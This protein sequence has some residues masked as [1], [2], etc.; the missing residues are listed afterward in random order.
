MLAFF[1]KQQQ[2]ATYRPMMAAKVD[3]AEQHNAWNQSLGSLHAPS[4]QCNSI[5]KRRR[6]RCEGRLCRATSCVGRYFYVHGKVSRGATTGSRP[7]KDWY[8]LVMMFFVR[9]LHLFGRTA[10]KTSTYPRSET[11]GLSVDV[12]GPRRTGPSAPGDADHNFCSEA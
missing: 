5:C 7:H 9:E 8:G 3:R 6:R 1:V 4:V 11:C 12:D 10:G 2:C